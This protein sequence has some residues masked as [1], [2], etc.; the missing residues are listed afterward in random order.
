ME[1]VQAVKKVNSISRVGLNFRRR[2]ILCTTFCRNP[3]QAS[4]FGGIF[5]QFSFVFFNAIFTENASLLC[6]YHG[7]K[8]S[9]MTKNSNQGACHS[10]KNFKL[11]DIYNRIHLQFLG[12]AM[13][14]DQLALCT[15]V[16]MV[17]DPKLGLTRLWIAVHT[18]KA[19]SELEALSSIAHMKMAGIAFQLRVFTPLCRWP[20][21]QT[22]MVYLSTMTIPMLG[23]TCGKAPEAQ[24]TIPTTPRLAAESAL[25]EYVTETSLFGWCTANI[26]C[27][28]HDEKAR[29][30][31]HVPFANGMRSSPQHVSPKKQNLFFH[32]PFILSFLSLRLLGFKILIGTEQAKSKVFFLCLAFFFVNDDV[33]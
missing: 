23:W 22:P 24:N 27:T 5:N 19:P 10:K 20:Q 13:T 30:M 17:M 25:L 29:G 28:C 14:M 16:S 8:E 4:N 12:F 6:L 33:P 11:K 26:N 9:K 31:L 21:T 2:P 7:A 32:H 1:I 3:V 15:T 18:H